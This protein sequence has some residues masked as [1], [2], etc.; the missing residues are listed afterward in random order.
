MQEYLRS[1]LRLGWLLNPKDR[2][3]EIYRAG[4]AV[5]MLQAPTALSGE[6]VLPNFTLNLD[7]F[8]R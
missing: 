1:G 4:Q 5:Q 8:W 2:Q 7:W 6:D 3:V